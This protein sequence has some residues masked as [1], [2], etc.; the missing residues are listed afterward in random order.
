VEEVGRGAGARERRRDLAADDA[1]LSHAGDD[2][3]AAAL[4]QDPDRLIESIVEAIDQRQDRA[5]SVSR[6]L[7]ANAMSATVSRVTPRP[8][9]G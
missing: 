2:H 6:T 4:A 5:A 7:R 1:G 9:S 8:G 3:A